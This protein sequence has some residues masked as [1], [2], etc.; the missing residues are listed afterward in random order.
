MVRP[1]GFEPATYGFVVRRSVR[2]ELRAQINMID[3][4]LTLKLY[5]IG[6]QYLFKSHDPI[7]S[8]SMVTRHI[9]YMQL[10]IEE[11]KKAGQKAEVPIGAVL[12]AESGDLLSRSYNQTI[13]LADPTAHAEVL[14][15]RAGAQ[16]LSNYRLL[17]TTLYVTV[18]PCIM[19]MG[20]IVHARVA[21]LVFGT[22]DPKW[23]AAGSLYNLAADKRLNHQPE[24][25]SGI[26][27]DECRRLMQDFFRDR[28]T[29][30]A[31]I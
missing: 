9:R 7:N 17:N 29:K 19:C 4:R 18:E 8:D 16:K 2:A 25:L 24:I 10:A 13:S 21:R 11:A 27:Q 26:C 1:A 22:S 12:V 23:G 3:I 31:K 30:A 28:R 15:L 14:A 6:C 5:R 20:A